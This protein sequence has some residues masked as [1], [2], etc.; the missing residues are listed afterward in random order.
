MYFASTIG[1]LERKLDE[2][3][4]KVSQMMIK[5]PLVQQRKTQQRIEPRKVHNPKPTPLQESPKKSRKLR[6]K[7]KKNDVILMPYID[8]ATIDPFKNLMTSYL[9]L[10]GMDYV[11][12]GDFPCSASLAID[13]CLIHRKTVRDFQIICERMGSWC[14][15]FVVTRGRIGELIAYFKKEIKL[16]KVTNKTITFVKKEFEDNVRYPARND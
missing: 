12:K 10:D 16:L 5:T 8:P 13:S 4:K 7:G 6:Q 15:G 14:K 3:S 2:T 1:E 11:A 9:R